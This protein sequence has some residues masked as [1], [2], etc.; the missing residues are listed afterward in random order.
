VVEP[1]PEPH[2]A[3]TAAEAARGPRA[4][5][6][7]LLPLRPV[8]VPPPADVLAFAVSEDPARLASPTVGEPTVAPPPKRAVTPEVI[9]GPDEPYIKPVHMVGPAGPSVHLPR[10]LVLP[11][12]PLPRE[13]RA[14]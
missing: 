7:R 12:L 6:M 1:C 3:V 11:L 2:A 9:E 13:S 8:L 14:V 5:V 4:L 10:T